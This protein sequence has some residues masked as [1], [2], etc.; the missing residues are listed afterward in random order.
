[1]ISSN[2]EMNHNDQ[3]RTYKRSESVVFLKTKEAFGGLS[4]MAGG[5]PL[6][7][8]GIKIRTTE[9]LY[10]ICRFP[11]L[12]DV[13]NLIIEQKSP[14]T[15]KMK[16]KPHRENSRKDWDKVRVKIMRWCLQV[17]LAQNWDKFS[18]LLLDTENKPI[19][20][21]SR[22]DSFWGAKPV[23][24]E[25][26]VGMNVLGRLLM[27]QREAVK[28]EN[29]ESLL[30]VLPLDIPN[31]EIAGSPIET[32]TSLVIGPT[33]S[34][35]ESAESNDDSEPGMQ[36]SLLFDEPEDNDIASQV[37]TATEAAPADYEVSNP[38]PVNSSDSEFKSKKDHLANI[39]ETF[40]KEFGDITWGDV[41]QVR[42]VITKDIPAIVATDSVYKKAK[43][44]LDKSLARI[45]HDKALTRAMK[46]V[47]R[48]D[49]E[50]HSQFVD[51]LFFKRWMM[52]ALFD[53]NYDQSP[54]DI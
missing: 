34:P 38:A 16:S 19:V 1:M 31:F 49:S 14:M 18:K 2:S 4:N 51:N 41:D 6:S 15:A 10:Q 13:Q 45:E 5:F 21:Q 52:D 47:V 46:V 32:A 20:E 39:I 43:Q 44:S 36:T 3:T 12:P 40:N 17:K 53:L 30:Q 28:N 23:D 54:M 48:K 29:K 33:N 22:R 26:L 9:A 24:D 42:K 27:E 7:I 11:H 37:N 35:T 8:N 50:L 25:T